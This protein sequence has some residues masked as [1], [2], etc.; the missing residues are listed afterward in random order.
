MI[1]ELKNLK[2]KIMRGTTTESDVDIINEAITYIKQL[3]AVAE[4]TIQ[5]PSQEDFCME[6]NSVN[7]SIQSATINIYTQ[8]SK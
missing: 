5:I 6:P 4:K 7:V 8:E 1:N 3:E 2:G